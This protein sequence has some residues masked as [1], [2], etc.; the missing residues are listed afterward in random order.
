MRGTVRLEQKSD[1]ELGDA[2]RARSRDFHETRG[3]EVARWVGE[4]S[5]VEDVKRVDAKLETT[6]FVDGQIFSKADICV[7]EA[8]P[9][10]RQAHRVANL[11]ERFGT[12]KACRACRRSFRTAEPEAVRV[13]GDVTKIKVA[14]AASVEIGDIEIKSADIGVINAITQQDRAPLAKREVPVTVHPSVRREVCP[15]SLLNG[16]L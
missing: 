7:V 5:V 1:G 6:L 16:T 8:G 14:N 9:D 2:S 3:S 11:P 12:I 10:D 13:R 15:R 4:L